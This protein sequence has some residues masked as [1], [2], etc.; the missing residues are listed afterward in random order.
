MSSLENIPAGADD[1]NKT[2]NGTEQQVNVQNLQAPLLG[3][4][5]GASGTG[6]VHEEDQKTDASNEKKFELKQG[7]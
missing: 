2:D 3:T 6:K 1:S 4:A 7:I 5:D